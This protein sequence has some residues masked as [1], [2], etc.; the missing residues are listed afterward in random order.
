MYGEEIRR[1]FGFHGS[2]FKKIPETL[3]F[4]MRYMV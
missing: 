1:D 3:D 4:S 2:F